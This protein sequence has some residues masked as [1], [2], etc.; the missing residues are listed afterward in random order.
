MGPENKKMTHLK[1]INT[2]VRVKMCLYI[3]LVCF[4]LWVAYL[5]CFL[6]LLEPV[7]FE[8]IGELTTATQSAVISDCV[9]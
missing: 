8:S 6:T 9:H 5:L 3:S 2:E 7:H 4:A 1:G